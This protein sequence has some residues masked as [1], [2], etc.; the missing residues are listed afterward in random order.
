MAVQLTGYQGPRGFKAEQVYDKSGQ[1]MQQAKQDAQY[2]EDAFAS[3]KEGVQRLGADIEKN[4]ENDLRALSQF[5]STLSEFLVDY[6]KKQ[7]DK[8]YKLGLAEVM[9]GNVEFPQQTIEQHNR[10]ANTL[11]AAATAD[12]EVANQIENPELS[13]TFRQESPAI[14]GWRAYGRAVG[15]AK[16]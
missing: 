5:S 15:T 16:K 8:E 2:R 4:Q 3:Y 9:N 12:G 6:Q 13:A 7:N 10:E 14:K 1:M 11:Q